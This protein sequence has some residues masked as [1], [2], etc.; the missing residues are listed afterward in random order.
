MDINPIIN[1]TVVPKIKEKD[2]VRANTKDSSKETTEKKEKIASKR[3]IVSEEERVTSKQIRQVVDEANEKLTFANA[4]YE[5]FYNSEKDRMSV[6]IINKDTKE[7][8]GEI[9]SD[10]VIKLLENIWEVTGLI[11]DERI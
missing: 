9:P 4:K 11:I 2:Y 7:V 6:K 3:I 10:N 8:V 5:L 1:P